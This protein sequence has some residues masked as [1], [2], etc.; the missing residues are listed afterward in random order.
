MYTNTSEPKIHSLKVNIYISDKMACLQLPGQE[1]PFS[2]LQHEGCVVCFP[3]PAPLVACSSLTLGASAKTRLTILQC[4]PLH[5]PA[6]TSLIVYSHP[7]A[8]LCHQSFTL[9]LLAC[10]EPRF[11]VLTHRSTYRKIGTF[12]PFYLLSSARQK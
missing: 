10:A 7:F 4:C 6:T 12:L 9:F 11:T 3:S 1:K 2:F 8:L 5:G